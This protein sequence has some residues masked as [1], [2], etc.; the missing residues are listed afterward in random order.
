MIFEIVIVLE[1]N[2]EL[3]N[4]GQH[5]LVHVFIPTKSKD[6]RTSADVPITVLIK[7]KWFDK[8]LGSPTCLVSYLK[9]FK[10]PSALQRNTLYDLQEH[11]HVTPP[12]PTPPKHDL[13]SLI[14]ALN[15]K[16]KHVH[17]QR[18]HEA[19]LSNVLNAVTGELQLTLLTS[20]TL[21]DLRDI[22]TE[23][24]AIWL[25]SP[26]W[27]ERKG[28]EQDTHLETIEILFW[29][30]NASNIPGWKA[31]TVQANKIDTAGSAQGWVAYKMQTYCRFRLAVTP[32][33]FRLSAPPR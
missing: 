16:Q 21:I 22:Y 28:L 15:Q 26:T 4:L 33:T 12:H 3:V 32:R 23:K 30:N 14:C 31:S 7:P 13:S 1:T 24:H 6:E 8:S 29:S 5:H 17:M 9:L 25:I 19:V 27:T 20:T 18:R 2:H 11:T 10:T